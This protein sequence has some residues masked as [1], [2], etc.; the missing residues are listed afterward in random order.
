MSAE[1]SVCKEQ[2]LDSLG[3]SI[4]VDTLQ[5][6]SKFITVFG[7]VEVISDQRAK[8]TALYSADVK[9]ELK[10]F[11]S[12]REK[13][14]L[15]RRKAYTAVA[16][17]SR[18]RRYRLTKNYKAGVT[19]AGVLKAYFGRTIQL[20]PAAK[21]KAPTP[22]PAREDPL[23]PNASFPD[24][25]VECK[26]VPD[27]RMR[28]TGDH[29]TEQ[30]RSTLLTTSGVQQQSNFASMK[31]YL[32]RRLLTKPYDEGRTVYTCAKCGA[33]FLSRDGFTYHIQSRGCGKR[34]KTKAALAA[35]LREQVEERLVKHVRRN[36]GRARRSRN[37]AP[38]YPQVWMHL[39]F[40]VPPAT[41]AI[42]KELQGVDRYPQLAEPDRTL[43]QLREQIRI[44]R[45]KSLG[46]VYPAVWNFLGLSKPGAKQQR[47]R[48]AS[49]RRAKRQEAKA[50]KDKKRKPE[51]T[52]KEAEL[53]TEE[54]R[55]DLAPV[56]SRRKKQKQ[57]DGMQ[58]VKPKFNYPIIDVQVLADEIKSGR[59][60][61]MKKY[62]GDHD[63]ICKICRDGGHLYCC[64]FCPSAVHMECLLAKLPLKD[65][66]TEDDFMCN[67]CIQKVLQ[68]RS[69]AEKRRQ[70]KNLTGTTRDGKRTTTSEGGAATSENQQ[71]ESS[72]SEY[73]R[74]A[75]IGQV[76]SEFSELLADARAR[77]HQM[78]EISRINNIRRLQVG[79]GGLLQWVQRG[80]AG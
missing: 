23:Y 41:E 9:N 71:E 16:F 54:D 8:P 77:L 30:E 32:R 5:P 2:T 21:W 50:T 49:L 65:S 33:Q 70:R 45:E 57:A 12:S 1:N 38:V 35:D 43:Q 15:S 72:A 19:G 60:P 67:R 6:G 24:R 76:L 40:M 37:L 59:Y 56:S 22:V 58:P 79:V 52:N 64:D 10:K 11:N 18:L 74:V 36:S 3:G 7:V 13:A 62:E 39:G 75:S 4:A 27:L 73:H 28:V 44:E 66:S 51:T 78:V 61:S 46:P 68:R 48:R 80:G 47:A 25:I 26:L 34:N 29:P 17:Q 63:D 31:L 20:S 42:G 14:A 69:R 55:A 53:Q